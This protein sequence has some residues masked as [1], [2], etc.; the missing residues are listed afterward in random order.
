MAGRVA[1]RVAE[2]ALGLL[3]LAAAFG[4]V[5][6]PL[7]GALAAAAAFVLVA[8]RLRSPAPDSPSRVP[9]LLDSSALIDGRIA[10]VAAAGFLEHELLLPGFVLAE[11]QRL[12]DAP[13]AARRQRGRRGLT[14][15][16][17]LK[18]KAPLTVVDDDA[19]HEAEVDAK[20]VDVAARRGAVLVT[21]D[22]N[23]GK[24]AAI[25]GLTVLNVNALALAL[26]P[27]VLPG[28]PLRVTVVKEGKEAGQGVAYLEDGTMVVVEQ[29][30]RRI[31]ETL[32]V[33]VTSAIQTAAGKMFFAK[34]NS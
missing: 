34:A 11:L 27:V 8:E 26:R 25:R 29:A 14:I 4:L 23:L 22:Y 2:G 19:P 15:V 17:T 12:A 32:D 10:E 3:L 16:E 9:A 5:A 31:G 20:L 6:W 28:E 13:D 7:A 30:Q 24:V 21:T 18:A 33:V 1:L